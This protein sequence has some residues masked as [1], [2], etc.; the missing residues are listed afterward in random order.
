[1]PLLCAKCHTVHFGCLNP[2]QQPH[3]AFFHKCLIPQFRFYKRLQQD[4]SALHQKRLQTL[5]IQMVHYLRQNTPLIIQRH[6]LHIR[7]HRL[8]MFREHKR[9]ST[10]IKQAQCGRKTQATV[11]YN[12][13]GED[14]ASCA[15][16]VRDYPI[17]Q[18]KCPP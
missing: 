17:P 9:A 18:C 13:Y 6:I 2:G 15:R 12:P 7:P 16:L 14:L 8:R 11:Q 10:P 3:G 4:T 5:I 1:M